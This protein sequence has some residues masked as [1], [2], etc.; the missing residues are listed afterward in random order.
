MPERKYD[1]PSD[2]EAIR[3]PGPTKSDVDGARDQFVR[4]IRDGLAAG[5]Y[6]FGDVLPTITEVRHQYGL[7]EED[8]HRA[9]RE[10]RRTEHVQLH[11]NYLDTYVLDPGPAHLAGEPRENLAE[12][13]TR[14]EAMYRD[15]AARVEAIEAPPSRP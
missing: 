5:L 2:L 1:R 9:I 11:D 7:Q 6:A 4:H 15:L 13:V 14:L 10:L 12:R 3:L 8:V